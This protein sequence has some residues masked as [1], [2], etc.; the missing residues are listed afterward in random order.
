MLSFSKITA[1]LLAAVCCSWGAA[2]LAA[3]NRPPSESGVIAIS[4][5]PF[6]RLH[7]VPVRAVELGE[8]FWKDRIDKNRDNS[9]PMLLRL[10]E[11]HG[12]VDNFRRL[13][14]RKNVERRGFLFTDSDLFK[15]IEAAAFTLGYNRA[16]KLEAALES[17]IDDVLAA[18]GR[19][20]YLNTY[21]VDERA[22]KR[23]TNFRSNHEL[24]CL[25]HLIQAAIAYYRATGRRAL[26]DGAVRYADYVISLFGPGKRQCF[27][28]H[29]EIE[30]ALVELY[31]TT[32]SRQ[33]LEFARYLLDGVDIGKIEEKVTE[34]D[35]M[36]LFSAL[37]FTSRREL[38]SHAVR[39]MYA[40]CGATDYYMETGDPEFRK[41]LEI[42][43]NDMTRYKMYITGGAGARYEGEAFGNPYELPNERAYTETCAAIGSIMWN[44]RMLCAT[45]EARF[46]DVLERALYNGFLAGVSLDGCSYFYRNPL[47]SIGNNER[48]AWHECTCCPPNVERM[49]ASLPGYLYSTSPEGLWV[50]FYHAGTLRW[51]LESGTGITVK[52]ETDYPWKGTI[53][54]I[55]EPERA[56]K[57]SLFLRLP[58][59]ASG[60]RVRVNGGGI[61][62]KYGPSEYC[63]INR[64]WQKGDR[65]TIVLSM[66]PRA[67]FANPRLENARGSVSL[68][69]GPLVYCLESPDN[70]GFPV[71]DVTL[72][73][74]LR[75]PSADITAKFLPGMLGGVA[76]LERRAFVYSSELQTHPLYGYEP[77]GERHRSVTARFIPYYAWANRG[78]SDM[79]VWM[80]YVNA[81][82][83]FHESGY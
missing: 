6:A 19:D 66:E 82:D 83:T 79:T 21:H 14:G 69:R 59:W 4:E 42:L 78:I 47:E 33:Y 1:V 22:D 60:A 23:F 10:L 25:G 17:V 74:Y 13:S 29:P 81:N 48:Q 46:A 27:P 30:M 80:P 51:K 31:R 2:G 37:P 16:P 15:W 40:C 49:L 7:D 28:G 58:G 73:L 5:S 34:S 45:G 57:F 65:V 26:L 32:G 77:Y 67:I 36:Y 41:T 11:E 20:G 9:I 61:A 24:Y 38:R 39:G 56:E 52:T 50:H 12:V 55:V 44:W 62:G 63:E 76:V 35:F 71:F 68:S 53:T 18:Q 3:P 54:L 64:A 8:G 75:H 70:P 43:W 72:P